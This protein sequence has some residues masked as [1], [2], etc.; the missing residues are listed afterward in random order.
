MGYT[1]FVVI[2]ETTAAELFANMLSDYNLQP[3]IFT[4]P[5]EALSRCR[6]DPPDLVIVEDDMSEMR[7]VDFLSA[8]LRISWTTSTILIT[9]DDEDVVHEK[10]EGLGIL[11]SVKGV[12]DS[13]G[14][15][16]LLKK[17]LA[18]LNISGAAI[19]CL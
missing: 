11:G 6:Q 1:A 3:T 16:P 8:L 9:E 17:A 19:G 7:G 12:E 4:D 5:H 18:I 13:E 14:L 2:N 10:T 15:A